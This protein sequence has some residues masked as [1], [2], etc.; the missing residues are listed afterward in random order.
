MGILNMNTQGKYVYLQCAG[1]GRR[2]GGGKY[3]HRE[4]NVF[5]GVI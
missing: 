3:P 4:E 2:M 5:Q 1:P